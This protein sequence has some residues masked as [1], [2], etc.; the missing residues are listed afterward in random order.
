MNGRVVDSCNGQVTG[1]SWNS[2][3]R[4][5]FRR[6]GTNCE[7]VTVVDGDAVLVRGVHRETTIFQAELTGTTVE[8]GPDAETTR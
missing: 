8:A 3:K 4:R 7:R 5:H 1:C 6:P 2:A